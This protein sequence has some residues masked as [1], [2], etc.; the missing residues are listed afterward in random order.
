M[1][2]A[3]TRAFNDAG[4]LRRIRP[5]DTTSL[6]V[7]AKDCSLLKGRTAGVYGCNLSPAVRSFFAGALQLIPRRS[8]SRRSAL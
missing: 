5:P 4:T 2:L 6:R 1:R 7:P 3:F 8:C